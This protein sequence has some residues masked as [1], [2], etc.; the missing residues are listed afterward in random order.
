[1]AAGGR[2][3]SLV[4]VNE[5]GGLTFAT[6]EGTGRCFIKW[7]PVGSGL[8]LVGEADRLAW[9]GQYHP[10]PQPLA[11]GHQGGG[12][13]LVTAALDGPLLLY[14]SGTR[15][16]PEIS[17]R[18]GRGGKTWYSACAGRGE[19]PEVPTGKISETPLMCVEQY[20]RSPVFAGV[21]RP[22]ADCDASWV[23]C[24][25]AGLD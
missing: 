19:R 15:D 11:Y 17:E 16:S 14:L 9:A 2:E 4:W 5:A 18:L 12:S 24:P 21:S 6:G 13:W 3:V 7:A 23:R 10:V 22:V 20:F 1:L 25:G 8:D